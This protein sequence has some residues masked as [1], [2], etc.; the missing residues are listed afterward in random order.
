MLDSEHLSLY[1]PRRSGSPSGALQINGASCN[2][3]IGMYTDNSQGH[4]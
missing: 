3:H 1:Q 2:Q 4:C